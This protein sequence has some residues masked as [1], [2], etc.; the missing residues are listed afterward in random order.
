MDIDRMV[1]TACARAG[2]D[3][4]GDDTW[5]EGLE[6]L[7]PSLGAEAAL[8]EMGVDAMTDQIVGY[9]VNRLQVE[10][11]YAKHPEIDDQEIVAPLF[12]LGLPRT[13]STAL[14]Y[15]LAQ[16]PARRSLRVWEASTPCPPPETATEHTDPRIAEAQAG[17]DFTNEMF[18]GF[19]GMLP[20]QADGPQECLLIMALDF[21]SQIFEGMARI[22]TYSSWLLQCDMVSTYRYHERVLKL[23]Q[24][25]CPPTT[26]SLRSPAH[27]H[28][29]DALDA[30]YPDARFVMTHRDVGKVLPSVCALYDSLS[31]V[32]SDRPDPIGIG[33]TNTAVWK[34]SLERAMAFRDRNADRFHD[35]RFDDV[36]RDPIGAVSRLYA[37]LGDRL[38][39]DARQRMQDWWTASAE[40]RPPAHQY[41]PEKYGLDLSA[42]RDQFAFYHDQFDMVR[43]I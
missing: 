35:L 24:W 39:P 7:D 4:L 16:D 37:E 9:L 3:D 31:S 38:T 33:T 10:Q 41:P 8:N 22:P 15:L 13:A 40:Q 27:M 34:L 30:V 25:R 28:S 26:W 6:V 2:S 1:D 17:I 18:P 23:L 42:I 11:W 12:G 32:L 5:R 19:F 21:R 14:G 29:I 43:E 36:Q 20:T